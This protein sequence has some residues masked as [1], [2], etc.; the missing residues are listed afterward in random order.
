MYAHTDAQTVSVIGRSITG[1]YKSFVAVS[2]S[3]VPY[4]AEL[5]VVYHRKQWMIHYHLYNFLWEDHDAFLSCV[6]R[7][8]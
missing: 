1:C 8:G 5:S 7:Q 2:S 3:I 6:Q 4:L